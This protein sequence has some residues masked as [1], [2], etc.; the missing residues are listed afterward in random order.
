MA[1]TFPIKLFDKTTGTQTGTLGGAYGKA[2]GAFWKPLGLCAIGQTLY[3]LDLPEDTAPLRVRLQAFDTTDDGWTFLWAARADVTGVSWPWAL[4]QVSDTSGWWFL[5]SGMQRLTP[6]VTDGTDLYFIVR[7]ITAASN[8]RLEMIKFAGADGTVLAR[9]LLLETRYGDVQGCCYHAATG[10]L[11]YTKWDN[12]NLTINDVRRIDTNLT[13]LTSIKTR[14]LYFLGRKLSLADGGGN[15]ILESLTTDS[16]HHGYGWGVY[17]VLASTWASSNSDYVES[18][19]QLIAATATD[20]LLIEATTV[21]G[22]EPLITR[23]TRGRTGTLINSFAHFQE[24]SAS[25]NRPGY[26][27]LSWYATTVLAD[28]RV[29]LLDQSWMEDLD[30]LVD[31]FGFLHVA[32]TSG[33]PYNPLGGL[34]TTRYQGPD[35]TW[36]TWHSLGAGYYHPRFRLGSDGTLWLTALKGAVFN[37]RYR[38]PYSGTWTVWKSQDGGDSW[39]KTSGV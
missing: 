25:G 21:F 32:D 1:F 33:G 5:G 18:S 23:Y 19:S 7:S 26:Y 11:Y 12:V 31:R 14:D 20:M 30:V 29:A 3:V 34:L 6:M 9:K 2:D 39:T 22:Q 36:S 37:T 35:G 16:Y 17:G 8:Q 28:G 4:G 13:T 10:A 24:G 38:S 15:V 27:G